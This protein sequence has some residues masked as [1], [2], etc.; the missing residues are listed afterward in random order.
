MK[1]IAQDVQERNRSLRV[2]LDLKLPDRA[3]ICEL[4][5]WHRPP[6]VVAD[7]WS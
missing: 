1:I 6:T 2:L 5:R 3:A 7:L 4:R